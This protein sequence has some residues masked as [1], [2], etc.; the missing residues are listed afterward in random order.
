M[1][2]LDGFECGDFDKNAETLENFLAP[3]RLRR[4][5]RRAEINEINELETSDDPELASQGRLLRHI[6]KRQNR[7]ARMAGYEDHVDQQFAES[8]LQ[9]LRFLVSVPCIQLRESAR[10]QLD[11]LLRDFPQLNG[12]HNGK[13]D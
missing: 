2:D 1:E 4:K 5:Y 13:S 11:K 7:V 12:G 8:D 6:L 9:R 10:S 3:E